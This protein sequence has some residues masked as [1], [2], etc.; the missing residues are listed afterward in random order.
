MPTC[1]KS[2]REVEGIPL[3]SLP[4]FTSE[5]SIEQFYTE[6]QSHGDRHGTRKLRE[7]VESYI[8]HRDLTNRRLEEAQKALL[9]VNGIRTPEQVKRDVIKTL[10]R[11]ARLYYESI[12]DKA[13]SQHCIMYHL[14]Y[15]DY[16]SR[17]ECINALV[18]K[19]VAD[20]MKKRSKE[21]VE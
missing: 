10:T 18:D 16:P 8:L 1:R 9:V 7:S 4:D 13:L 11:R 3:L 2:K 5:D 21:E 12:T 19:H 20:E 17:E 14:Y 6:L 15:D